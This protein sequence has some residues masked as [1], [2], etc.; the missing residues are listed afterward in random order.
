MPTR[1]RM[2]SSGTPGGAFEIIAKREGERAGLVLP[3]GIMCRGK[4]DGIRTALEI[5]AHDM[6]SR[7]IIPA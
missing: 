1:N 6:R 4:R 3:S 7:P 2:P 5:G